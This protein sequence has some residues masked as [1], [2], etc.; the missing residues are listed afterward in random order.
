MI[1]YGHPNDGIDEVLVPHIFYEGSQGLEYTRDPTNLLGVWCIFV[2][3][4]EDHTHLTDIFRWSVTIA[5]QMTRRIFL[6]L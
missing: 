6:L 5:D 3:L 1:K 4:S 2:I